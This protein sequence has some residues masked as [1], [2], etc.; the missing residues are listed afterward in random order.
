MQVKAKGDNIPDTLVPA[1]MELPLPVTVQVVNST[2]S[3]C[4]EEIYDTGDVQ[5]NS[6]TS[7]KAKTSNP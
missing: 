6:A 3:T 2:N 1:P 4:F 7:F 5:Q